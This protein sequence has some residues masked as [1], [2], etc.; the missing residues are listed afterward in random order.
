MTAH[1]H[2]DPDITVIAKVGKPYGLKGFNTLLL[3]TESLDFKPNTEYFIQAHSPPWAPLI[4]TDTAQHH[5]KLRVRFEG[6]HTPEAAAALTG[7]LIGIRTATFPALPTGEYYH[8]QLIGLDVTHLKTEPLGKI[9]HIWS[10]GAHDVFEV[11]SDTHTRVLPYIDS[12]V[13]CIDLDQHTMDVN[14]PYDF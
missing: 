9:T 5:H 1:T 3:F 13:M 10:N 7:A 4:C 6:T 2:S 12:V 14:W 8:Q 11:K